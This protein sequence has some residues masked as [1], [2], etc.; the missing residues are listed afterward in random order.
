[1]FVCECV[2]VC[3]TLHTILMGSVEDT[4]VTPPHR[5]RPSS[6]PYFEGGENFLCTAFIAP[7]VCMYICMLDGV[8]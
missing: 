7:S 2:G 3:Y 8:E 4:E 1:M 6:E 5:T